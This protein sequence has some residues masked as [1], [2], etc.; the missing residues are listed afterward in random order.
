MMA[1]SVKG[2]FNYAFPLR[3]IGR[4]LRILFVSNLFASFGDGLTIFLLPLFIRDLNATPEQV[5]LLYSV[6][7]IASATTIIPGGLLAAKYDL[8]KIMVAGWAVWVPVPLLFAMATNWMHFIPAM[9]FYG[10]LFSGPASSAYIAGRAQEG[11]MTSTFSILAAAWGL[12]Y[13]FA[14]TVAGL[15]TGPIGTKGVFV[16]TAVFYLA[17]TLMLTLIRSQRPQKDGPGTVAQT[18][19]DTCVVNRLRIFH[20][21]VLFGTV[22]FFVSLVVPLV[23]QFLKDIYGYDVDL[24]GIMGSFTYFGG[25]ALSIGL[26]KIGDRYGKLAPISVAMIVFALALGVFITVSNFSFLVLASFLRGASFPMWAF[27]GATVGSTVPA[28]SRAKWISVVQTVA[29]TSSVLAPYI[30]GVLYVYSPRAPFYV[31][32]VAS[33]ALAL[34]ARFM[35]LRDARP[36]LLAEKENF[37][38]TCPS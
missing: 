28:S 22:M 20:L 37:A 7:M 33:L 24:I 10:V 8:K 34:L 26:G 19:N 13:M 30:G 6:L 3:A 38:V 35:A 27:L 21:S 2:L 9:F 23:P 11:K 15:L 32:I 29:Q 4:D 25:S 17:T 36:R 18:A 5:G 14:P 12:G 31:A 1:A 16:L